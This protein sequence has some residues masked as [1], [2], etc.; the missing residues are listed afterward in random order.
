MES[1]RKFISTCPLINIVLLYS[2]R[3]MEKKNSIITLLNISIL[4]PIFLVACAFFFPGEALSNSKPDISQPN[5]ILIVLDAARADHFSCYGYNKNTTPHMDA[6]AEKGAIFLNNF[7]N[8][9]FTLGSVSK[10]F[11]SRYYTVYVFQ[12]D[13][14]RWKTRLVEC[15]YIF[16]DFD[17]EQILLPKELSLNGYRTSLFHNCYF[18]KKDPLGQTFDQN[19]WLKPNEKAIDT[20]I[21]WIKNN[22]NCKF[23]IYCHIMCPHAPYILKDEDNEFLADEDPL[24]IKLVRESANIKNYDTFNKDNKENFRILRG[25]YDGNLKYIDNKIGLLYDKLEKLGLTDNTLVII[26]ADHGENLGEH[27]S[28]F[29]STLPWDSV[30]RVPLIMVYPP[31]IPPR[32]KVKA[33]TELIDIPPTILDITGTKL[34]LGKTMDGISLLEALQNR[35]RGK[36]AVF[37]NNSIRTQKYK[38]IISKNL[39]YDLENDPHET[40]NISEEKTLIKNMLKEQFDSVMK[41][42]KNRFI[43]TREKKIFHSPFFLKINCFTIFPKKTFEKYYELQR[44]KTMLSDNTLTGKSWFLNKE[45][46]RTGLICIPENGLPPAISLS[47]HMPNGNY[48]IFVLLESLNEASLLPEKFGF[49]SRFSTDQPYTFPE[50]I[51]LMKRNNSNFYYLNLGKSNVQNE[52]FFSQILFRPYDKQRFVIRHVKFVPIQTATKRVF[53]GMSDEEFKEKT[54]RLKSL[55]YL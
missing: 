15:K 36:Y 41:P 40:K 4:T 50:Q 38:Y 42:Y 51:K 20:I 37:T 3:F 48:H 17:N 54:E 9:T 12:D 43:N 39:L 49:Q 26:T 1:I 23:F 35:G 10:M 28:L 27:G 45:R 6:I 11:C 2:V 13:F 24:R 16:R 46:F 55:G 53:E 29:H 21:S 22:K 44:D 18:T 25:L 8:E 31:L 47:I 32:T 33:L 14:W 5:I 7:S 30:T 19:F 34:P 52:N